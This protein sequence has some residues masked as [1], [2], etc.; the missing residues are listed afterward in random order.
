VLPPFCLPSSPG[1]LQGPGQTPMLTEETASP[2]SSPAARPTAELRPFRQDL[3]HRRT[4][5]REVS[6]LSR[7]TAGAPGAGRGR[8][9]CRRTWEDPR[10]QLCR[11]P[12]GR[13]PCLAGCSCLCA[14]SSVVFKR[15][16]P[17]CNQ[18]LW[19][20]QLSDCPSQ[21]STRLTEDFTYFFCTSL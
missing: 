15:S 20:I 1:N 10:G 9:G 6:Q 21:H 18:C 8:L 11:S 13:T 2:A 4:G 17:L 12:R 19:I 5:E 3:P 7:E 14:L 16:K